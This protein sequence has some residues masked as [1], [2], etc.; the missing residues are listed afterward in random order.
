MADPDRACSLQ[1]DPV[2]VEVVL[3]G[4]QRV[5]RCQLA[6]PPGTTAVQAMEAAFRLPNWPP[7]P[8]AIKHLGVFGRRVEPDWLMR[9]GDRLEIYRALQLDPK[10]ARRRR[11]KGRA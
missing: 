10:E 2:G 1:Q 4:E 8:T 9:D 7:I 11:A 3:A 6:L 5:W